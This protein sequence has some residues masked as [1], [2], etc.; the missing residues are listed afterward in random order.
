M[1]SVH[2]SAM[3]ISVCEERMVVGGGGGGGGGG[4]GAQLIALRREGIVL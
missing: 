2:V 4:E 1:I 3:Y